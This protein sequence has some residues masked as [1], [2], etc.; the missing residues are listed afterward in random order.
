MSYSM[1]Y[2][3]KS[4]PQSEEIP[5]KVQVKNNAGGYVFA[6]NEWDNLMRF[7]ILGTMGGTYYASEHELT[8]ENAKN[9]E[10]LIAK[11]GIRVVDTVVEVSESGRAPK[12]DPA[13]FVLALCA[14]CDNQAVVKYALSKLSKVARIGTHLFTFL[15]YVTSNRGWGRGLREAV[16]SW[17]NDKDTKS[18]SYQVI[19]YQQR[20]GWSNRDALRLSHPKAADQDHQKIYKWIVSGEWTGEKDG[21]I[22]AAEEAKNAISSKDI[23]NLIYKYNLPRES[24]PTEW[25]KD[26]LVWRA[27]LDKGMPMTALIRNLGVMTAN[28]TLIP[29]SATTKKVAAQISNEEALKKARVHPVQIL[30]A[31]GTYGAGRGMKGSL[32]WS[33]IGAISSA[34]EEAF[35]KSFANVEPSGKR[36]MIALDVSGSMGCGDVGGSHSTPCEVAAAMSLVTMKT[37][38]ETHVMAFNN[39]IQPL[40]ISKYE[41]IEGVMKKTSN[42][43]FGGTDCALPMLYAME[44]GIEVDGF[45]VY[46]DNETWAG[47]VHPCQA[48]NKY[49]RKTG[50]PAKLVVV[51]LTS[52]G[53]TIADPSDRGMLDVVGMD[54]N[55]PALISRFIAGEF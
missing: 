55:A 12:N 9:I 24:I 10:A 21:L 51:G 32:S 20:N 36:I 37:E 13:L 26:C 48:L 29:L 33:P 50:I 15:E 45:V 4:T 34:L 28:K 8:V 43:N 46:T 49:R 53:F 17:Y 30:L 38:P 3:R 18:L 22:F 5:G 19:K 44:Q 23:C 7:L 2:S 47:L 27:M 52:T 6:V 54:A 35:Y 39:R 14:S 40:N 25:L 11:D 1:H 16:A 41:T 31:K 42:I